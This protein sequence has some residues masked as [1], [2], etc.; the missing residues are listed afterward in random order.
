MRGDF[1]AKTVD[2][3]IRIDSEVKADVENI[4]AQYGMS[5]ADAINVFLYTSRNK[6]GL[7]FEL[8]PSVSNAETLEAIEEVRRMKADPSLGKGYTDIDQMMKELLE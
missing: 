5:I 3:H 8:R 6:G 2:M 4:Y 7:P 1:M